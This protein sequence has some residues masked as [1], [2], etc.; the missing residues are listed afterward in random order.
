MKT[1]RGNSTGANRENG[2]GK[3]N[4]CSLR[5]LLFKSGPGDFLVWHDRFKTSVLAQAA[6]RSF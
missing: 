6:T 3:E 2:E 4:L 5:S 1:R